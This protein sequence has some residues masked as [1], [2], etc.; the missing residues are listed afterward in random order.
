ALTGTGVVPLSLSATTAAFGN[1]GVNV[2][3]IPKTIYFFNYSGNSI[4]PVIPASAGSFTTAAGSC[5]NPVGTGGVCAFTV[6]FTPATTGATSA[7]LNVQAG[8]TTL[9]LALTGTGVVPLSL[10]TSTAAFGNQ[11]VNVPSIPKTI[12][13]FNY[14]GSSITP[15]IPASAGSFTTAAG[16]CANPVPNGL[17]CT[18]TVT[19]TPATTGATSGTLNVQAGAT[20][21]PLMLTGTGQ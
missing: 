2:P 10:S 5:A 13:F 21:L 3:S 19:F 1:Q 6:T 12:Y 16:T 8:A 20:T 7:T 11:G 4:T 17:S 14:S 15:V 9:P 18:F